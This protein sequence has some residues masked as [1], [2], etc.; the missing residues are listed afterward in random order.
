MAKLNN[1]DSPSPVLPERMLLDT[2]TELVHPDLANLLQK[3]EKAQGDT[4]AKVVTG[5]RGYTVG[6]F[7]LK[8]Y[9]APRDPTDSTPY[10]LRVV[11][12]YHAA[13]KSGANYERIRA[14]YLDAD[15]NRNQFALELPSVAKSG[16]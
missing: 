11:L 15:P 4:L 2:G 9:V 12:E 3:L 7:S 16:K 1:D 10:E 13:A 14:A 5:L 6:G 8:V